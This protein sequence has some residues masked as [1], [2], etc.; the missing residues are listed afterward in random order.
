[1]ESNKI[2]CDTDVLI[3]YFD[4]AK[5]RHRATQQII[6]NEIGLDNIVIPAITKMEL[7]AGV[8]NKAELR[9]L[10]KNIYRLN[11]FLINPE[12]SSIGI[13][14]IEAYKL[15][16]GLNIADALIAATAIY[17]DLRLFTYN[18]KDYKF[19]DGLKLYNAVRV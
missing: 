16:H 12:I 6:E 17:T 10:N 8:I 14:L 15:S 9:L 19:I 13:N 5:S 2:I 3:D 7:I 11:L 4:T 1:M 18:T